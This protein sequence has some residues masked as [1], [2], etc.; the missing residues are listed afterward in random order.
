MA[1]PAAILFDL[2]DTLLDRS[3]MLEG[4]A[5]AFESD[6][7]ERLDDV[8]TAGVE[9]VLRRADRGGYHQGRRSRDLLLWLRWKRPPHADELDRHFERCAPRAAVTR[10]GARETLE[11][12]RARRLPIGLVTNGREHPQREKLSHTRLLELL[13]TVVISESANV[14][15]PEPA[16][17][18]LAAAQ[19]GA[20]AAETWFVGD[21]PRND[22][23]GAAAAG[24]VPVW[25]RGRHP[26]PR[27]EAL[28]ERAIDRLPELIELVDRELDPARGAPAWPTR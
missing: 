25:L 20:R 13:D 9:R 10:E 3:R 2:D 22:V 23:L 26:W 7:R 1:E 14:E 28:P 11:A 24:L 12:L 21:H 4:Y 17:F 27:S 16:I 8:S 5:R 18:A 19:L 6:F 15:K